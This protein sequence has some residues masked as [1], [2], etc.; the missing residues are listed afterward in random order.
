[1]NG[2]T[3]AGSLG[4]DPPRMECHWRMKCSHGRKNFTH[5]QGTVRSIIMAEADLSPGMNGKSA[6]RAD[7]AKFMVCVR[8]MSVRKVSVKALLAWHSWVS[9]DVGWDIP[10]WSILPVW[11][12]QGGCWDGGDIHS[13][14]CNW[15]ARQVVHICHHCAWASVIDEVGTRYEPYVNLLAGLHVVGNV[16]RVNKIQFPTEVCVDWCNEVCCISLC[17]N[18][19]YGI[20]IYHQW[21]KIVD[22][23]HQ[24]AWLTS[25]ASPAEAWKLAT[26]LRAPGN[27]AVIGLLC[28]TTQPPQLT[29]SNG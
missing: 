11:D 23:I 15:A 16:T 6:T 21:I 26:R 3:D 19:A 17:A 18:A 5:Y 25:Q 22:W 29:A 8:K 4:I 27:P 10:Y 14:S 20:S 12:S 28:S 1:M 2:G 13:L 9:W 24:Q 7:L